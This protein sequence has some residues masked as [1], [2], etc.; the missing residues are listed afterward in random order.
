MKHYEISGT[1]YITTNDYPKGSFTREEELGTG[2]YTSFARA[3]KQAIQDKKDEIEELKE[4][5]I[6]LRLCKI[7]D[8]K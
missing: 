8:C 5:I 7:G 2:V 6:K 4:D 3:K 1:A